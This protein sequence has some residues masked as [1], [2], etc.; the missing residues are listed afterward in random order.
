[1]R[2]F[3]HLSAFAVLSLA[4]ANA[5]SVLADPVADITAFSV[6]KAEQVDLPKLARGEVM[7][8]H[9]P[10][11]KFAR[12][13]AVESIFVLPMPVQKANDLQKRWDGTQHDAL[14]I[15][16]HVDL[17]RKPSLQDFQ[18]IASAPGNSSVR[19][20]VSATEKLNPDRPGLQ[21]SAEEAKQFAKSDTGAKGAM[22]ANVSSFWAGLLHRRASAFLESGVPGQPGYAAGGRSVRAIDDANELLR[23]RPL[24]RRQFSAL[25]DTM[26]GGRSN[27]GLFYEL[28]DVEGR[29]ALTL[30]ASYSRATA[31]GW[32]GGVV[33]FYSSDGYYVMLTVTQMWPVQIGGKE[34]ALVWRGDFVSSGQL[35]ELRGIERAGAAVAMRKEIQKNVATMV[36][37]LSS[38]R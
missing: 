11:M 17:P 27:A 24:V 9:G 8:A 20:L 14:K 34:N 25:A 22:P 2:S 37:D 38:R 1:M 33:G 35:G 15:Y 31:D 19:A 13:L 26:L 36:R 4:V 10:A 6:F 29:A 16:Q 18:K 12:G 21:M 5:P 30:G 23:E 32:Q 3:T 7:V 28:F